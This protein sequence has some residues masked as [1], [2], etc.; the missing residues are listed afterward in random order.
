MVGKTKDP[1]GP[2]LQGYLHSKIEEL[3]LAARDK[4]LNLQ[5][6]EA[7]RN[8]LNAQGKAGKRLVA[9]Q[10]L[11]RRPGLPGACCESV[12]Q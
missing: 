6:L 7:Q 3:E 8:Q 11:C 9:V 10:W 2:G 12:N 5:R 4:T 1:S